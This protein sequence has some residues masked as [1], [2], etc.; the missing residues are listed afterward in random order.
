MSDRVGQKI[1]MA[2]FEDLFGGAEEKPAAPRK[3]NK[4]QV[5][6][7]PTDRLFGFRVVDPDHPGEYENHPFRVRDD[8]DMEK[9]VESVKESGVLTP[10]LIRTNPIADEGGYQIISGHRRAHAARMAEIPVVPAIVKEMDD[11]EA[12]IAMVDSNFQREK[13]LPSEWGEALKMK[14]QAIK[15]RAGRPQKNLS[16]GETNFDAAKVVGDDIGLGRNSVFKYIRITEL[17]NFLKELVDENR[18]SIKVAVSLSYLS[19]D[20]Q[21]SIQDYFEGS[22]VIISME[23]AEKLKK[24]SKALKT[25]KNPAKWKDLS[26]KQVWDMLSAEEKPR[27][28]SFTFSE[29]VYSRYFTGDE[30]KTEVQQIICEAL[31]D[32]LAKKGRKVD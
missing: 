10:L 19:K 28:Y 13:I 29:A 6:M 15:R 12:M 26:E 4:D 9:L 31:D 24:E 30:S 11:D 1:Q 21:H 16:P 25:D 8:E 23:Q 32:W 27:N 14:V 22:N 5:I 3:G 7:V 17:N 18:I 2:S 20:E